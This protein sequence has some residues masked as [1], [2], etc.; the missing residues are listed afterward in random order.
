VRRGLHA[1]ADVADPIVQR[2]GDDVS[3]H[4]LSN[5]R[6]CR[7]RA[8]DGEAVRDPV[9]LAGD[10]V[11]DALE[12]ERFE[13]ARGS[14]ARVSEGVPAVDD[15]GAPGVKLFGGVVVELPERDRDGAGKV[16]LLVLVARRTSTSW[17]PSASRR[18]GRS[19]AIGVGMRDLLSTALFEQP[20]EGLAAARDGLGH[21]EHLA[22]DHARRLQQTRVCRRDR[23]VGGRSRA[24]Q[25]RARAI[26]AGDSDRLGRGPR[27]QRSGRDPDLDRRSGGGAGRCTSSPH[28]SGQ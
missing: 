20:A 8:F 15:D 17:A 18:C 22:R 26:A 10:V 2:A 11:V 27:R 24:R 7:V 13:P 23:E 5:G 21:R 14:W 6:S 12:G 3:A 4:K 28:G 9:G 19:T 1:A 25:A 16:H